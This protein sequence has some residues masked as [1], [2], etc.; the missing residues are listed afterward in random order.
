MEYVRERGSYPDVPYATIVADFKQAHS[1]WL[2]V[3]ARGEQGDF[4]REPTA[5]R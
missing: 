4:A 2:E 1:R 5:G 3:R